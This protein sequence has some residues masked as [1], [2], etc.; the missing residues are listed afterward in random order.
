[1]L[2]TDGDSAGSIAGGVS[3]P[4]GMHAL[5][6]GFALLP[7]FSGRDDEFP[8]LCERRS[9]HGQ[10]GVPLC[11][12]ARATIRLIHGAPIPVYKSATWCRREDPPLNGEGLAARFLFTAS[13][14]RTK[15]SVK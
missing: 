7:H 2:A 8:R 13:C 4:L 14:S 9:E 1:T 10:E 5:Y 12:E 3:F 6:K 15:E 11:D